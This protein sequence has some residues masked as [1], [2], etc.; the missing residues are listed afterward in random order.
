MDG[1]A[2]RRNRETG[3]ITVLVSHRFSTVR[4]ADVIAV[5]ERGRIAEVGSHAELMDRDGLYAQLY[6]VTLRAL[7]RGG[8][9][10]G[11]QDVY[12]IVPPS[13]VDE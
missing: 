5:F 8:N 9:E 6:R 12:V 2:A 13:C 4:V 7:G 11:R 3:A 10:V 1:E